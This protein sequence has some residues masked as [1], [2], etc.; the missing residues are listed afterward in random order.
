[1]NAVNVFCTLGLVFSVSGFADVPTTDSHDELKAMLLSL[2]QQMAEINK[3]LHAQTLVDVSQMCQMYGGQPLQPATTQGELC[4][5][6][7]RKSG[8]I[9]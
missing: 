5:H 2:Q 7:F 6:H 4:W 8:L 1:M 9:S 3:T